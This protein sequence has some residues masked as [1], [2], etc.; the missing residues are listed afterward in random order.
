MIT[1]PLLI[2]TGFYIWFGVWLSKAFS[3][4]S[5]RIIVGLVMA[6]PAIYMIGS[7]Q[8]VKYEHKAACERDGGLRVFI[9]PEKAD[10]IRLDP[11]SFSSGGY[12]EDFLRTYSPRLK[13]VEAWDGEYRG[14]PQTRDHFSYSIDPAISAL[15]KKDWKF[16]KFNKVQL[17]EPTADLYVLSKTYKSEDDV[18]IQTWEL[19][20]NR[21]LYAKWTMFQHYWIKILGARLVSWQCFAPSSPEASG[22][23]P[24]HVIIQ[25]ILQ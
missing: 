18:A 12:A 17:A 21:Q 3:D 6:S 22:K 19:E 14:M 8:Y 20:R 24:N 4:R 15:E 1:I 5:S 2:L 11:N 23:Q 9:Q 16:N 25:L 7:Y 10:R 13:V